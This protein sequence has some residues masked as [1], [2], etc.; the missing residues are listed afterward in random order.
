MY[1][2]SRP[3]LIV[4]LSYT[5]TKIKIHNII[6]K[7]TLKFTYIDDRGEVQKKFLTFRNKITVLDTT[8]WNIKRGSQIHI[9]PYPKYQFYRPKKRLEKPKLI[10]FR[11]HV[12]RHTA[13][14]LICHRDNGNYPVPITG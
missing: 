4:R 5:K 13:V 14:L 10:R 12:K 6:G 3:A 8:T 1:G 9:N 11:C 7:T 2:K